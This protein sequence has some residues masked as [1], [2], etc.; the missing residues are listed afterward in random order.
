MREA[1]GHAFGRVAEGDVADHLG[2]DGRFRHPQGRGVKPGVGEL[3]ERGV[4]S[5]PVVHVKDRRA[6]LDPIEDRFIGSPVLGDIRVSP[7]QIFAG[8]L[9]WER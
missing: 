6:L 9:F 3:V 8:C 4:Q 1:E 5:V 2:G 7:G